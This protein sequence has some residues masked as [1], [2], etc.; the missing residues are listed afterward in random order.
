MFIGQ[1]VPSLTPAE[2]ISSPGNNNFY[3][4]NVESFNLTWQG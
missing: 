3:Y 1:E 2:P 4:E